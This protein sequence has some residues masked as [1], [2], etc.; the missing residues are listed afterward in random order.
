[1]KN[2]VCPKCGAEYRLQR[3]AIKEMDEDMFAPSTC[4]ECG[5]EFDWSDIEEE[6]NE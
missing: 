1:M 4:T 3:G 5:H 2:A 6:K